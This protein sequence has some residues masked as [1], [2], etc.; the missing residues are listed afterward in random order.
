VKRRLIS[1]AFVLAACA[2]AQSPAPAAAAKTPA[3]IPA[4]NWVLPLFDKEGFRSLTLRGEEA[5]ISGEQVAVKN[6]N[7]T[8]F[9][10]GPAAEVDAVLLSQAATAFP[11]T[12]RASG[13]GSVR[14]IRDDADVTGT[15]W[16][17]DH[18]RKRV[19]IRRD[20]RVVIHTPLND[21]LK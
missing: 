4:K 3:P 9:A 14:L 8:T 21:I 13:E 17:Y 15:G 16:E 20:V 5:T 2:Q 7:I 18:S 11:K 10:G 1:L 12:L 19:F 6:L